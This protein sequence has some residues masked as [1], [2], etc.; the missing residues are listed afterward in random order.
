ME[1]IRQAPGG[2]V[3]GEPLEITV[4]ISAS[5]AG[6]LTCSLAVDGTLKTVFTRPG[7][8]GK[9]KAGRKKK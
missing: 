4:T 9:T 5:F 6:G 1:L 2:Y 8:Q 3:P 7:F